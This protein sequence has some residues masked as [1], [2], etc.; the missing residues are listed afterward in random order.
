MEMLRTVPTIGADVTASA[1][2]YRV[3]DDN[4]LLVM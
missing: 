3:I 4:D 1:E 2:G